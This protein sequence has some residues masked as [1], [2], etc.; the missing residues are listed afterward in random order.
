MYTRAPPRSTGTSRSSPAPSVAKVS[1]GASI[2]CASAPRPSVS[3]KITSAAK[4][5]SSRAYRRTC[6]IPG[7]LT[8]IG[9][10]DS[11]TR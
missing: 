3:S 2:A 10:S 1:L 5:P 4:L 6:W 9:S 7:L 8:L 11:F